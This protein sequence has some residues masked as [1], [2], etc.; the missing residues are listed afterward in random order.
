MSN[1]L[2]LFS[3]VASLSLYQVASADNADC[4]LKVSQNEQQESSN[5]IH[6]NEIYVPQGSDLATYGFSGIFDLTLV[7]VSV[8]DGHYLASMSYGNSSVSQGFQ[9][10]VSLNFS[11]TIGTKMSLQ[12]PI[13]KQKYL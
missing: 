5:F 12:C 6:L 3:I 2:K 1:I 11:P 9:D 8:T 7:R 10:R 13:G 4:L